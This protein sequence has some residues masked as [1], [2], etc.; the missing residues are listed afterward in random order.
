MLR[1]VVSHVT[2][3]TAYCHGTGYNE[4]F[5]LME[6]SRS[7]HRLEQT[8]LERVAVFGNIFWFSQVL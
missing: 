8:V 6:G 1:T 3:L 7:V 2:V 4:S 5:G